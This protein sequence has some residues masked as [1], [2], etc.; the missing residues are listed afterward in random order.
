MSLDSFDDVVT[1][2]FSQ[3]TKKTTDDP[4]TRNDGVHY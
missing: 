2:F 4:F 1:K 3:P